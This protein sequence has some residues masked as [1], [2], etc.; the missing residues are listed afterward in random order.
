MSE[1]S[2]NAFLDRLGADEPFRGEVGLALQGRGNAAAATV[3]IAAQAGFDFTV[4]EL[5]A[6]LTRRYSAPELSDS[7]LDAVAG[8]AGVVGVTMNLSHGVSI[9]FPDVC[10][11]PSPGGPTPIPYPG[12]GTVAGDLGRPRKPGR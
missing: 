5:E 1:Q 8:G 7:Q 3:E 11:T 10:K 2:V 4:A 9:V 6:A 12:T